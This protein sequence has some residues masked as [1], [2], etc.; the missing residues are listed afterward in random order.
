MT[1]NRVWYTCSIDPLIKNRRETDS[2]TTIR[3]LVQCRWWVSCYIWY[4]EEGPGRVAAPPSTLLAVPNV[5]AHPSTAIVP[6]WQLHIIRC[7]F[8]MPVHSKGLNVRNTT[9]VDLLCTF[10]K[11]FDNGCSV[12]SRYKVCTL[13][14][15]AGWLYVGNVGDSRR[16]WRRR[17]R[18]RRERHL[19]FLRQ[20][21]IRV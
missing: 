20:Q 6:T 4:S 14:C 12:C 10:A 17:R 18:R 15:D 11:S 2:N 13:Y 9:Y 5:T 1:C 19:H 16:R 7:G 21:E 8:I 3:W